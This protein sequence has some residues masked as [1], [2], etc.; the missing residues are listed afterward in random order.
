MSHLT[1]VQ[2]SSDLERGSAPPAN[3]YVLVRRHHCWFAS[4]L[5]VRKHMQSGSLKLTQIDAKTVLRTNNMYR[6]AVG[7]HL[8]DAYLAFRQIRVTLGIYICMKYVAL[9][10]WSCTS[11]LH[12]AYY[13]LMGSAGSQFTCP[14]LAQSSQGKRHTYTS[15]HTE[16]V[17]DVITYKG[18]PQP[19]PSTSLMHQQTSGHLSYLAEYRPLFRE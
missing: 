12:L 4:I 3:L 10:I 19:A 7:P 6:F 18:F 15:Y 16:Q 2:S 11:C 9:G 17:D 1:Y 5:V 8:F 14:R 13:I